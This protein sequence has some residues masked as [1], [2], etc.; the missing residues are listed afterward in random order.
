MTAF[1]S[2]V[3]Y[4]TSDKVTAKDFDH[5]VSRGNEIIPMIE[6]KYIKRNKTMLFGIVFHK[7]N[8]EYDNC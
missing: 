4:V 1:Q 2:S 8:H 3:Y 6:K 5:Y 7:I